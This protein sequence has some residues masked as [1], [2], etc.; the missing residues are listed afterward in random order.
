VLLIS[1]LEEVDFPPRVHLERQ[2]PVVA[3]W[4]GRSYGAD[5]NEGFCP[6]LGA[7]ALPLASGSASKNGESATP[8]Y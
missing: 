3:R 1:F 2:V 8:E 6:G 7:S 4:P 5:A